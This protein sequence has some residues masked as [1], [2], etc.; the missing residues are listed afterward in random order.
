MTLTPVIRAAP[1][2]FAA[3]AGLKGWIFALCST[4]HT[5]CHSIKQSALVNIWMFLAHDPDGMIPGIGLDVYFCDLVGCV[6][7]SALALIDCVH[8]VA[9]FGF[10]LGSLHISGTS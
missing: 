10:N 8:R 6:E 9:P 3:T 2:K 5:G 4:I 7:A 1:G